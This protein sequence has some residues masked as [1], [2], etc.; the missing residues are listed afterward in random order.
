[1]RL[2]RRHTPSARPEHSQQQ[3]AG[4]AGTGDG[5]N[6]LAL[7]LAKQLAHGS[8]KC[9]YVPG[10]LDFVFFSHALDHSHIL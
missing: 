7:L 9:S 5:D 4:P 1:M 2:K 8:I 6:I 3:V 10:C